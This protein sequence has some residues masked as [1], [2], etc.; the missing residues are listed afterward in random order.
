MRGEDFDFLYS[1]EERYWWFVGMRRITD[2]LVGAELQ[3]PA[4]KILD[5]GCGTGYNLH[6]YAAA[7]HT[8]YGFDIAADAVAGV[9]RRG[10]TR[11]VQASVT[12]IPFRA[13][14]FDIVFSFDVICQIPPSTND[15]AI[16]EMHRVLK[17]GGLLFVRVPAFEWLRSSHDADLHTFHRFTLPEL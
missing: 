13:E 11:L 15:Q 1:L 7:G 5:A 6:H 14:T 2:T 9:Q 16:A 8:V 17:P 3:R 12:D 4:L 10:M